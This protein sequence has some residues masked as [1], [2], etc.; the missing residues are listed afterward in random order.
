MRKRFLKT[1]TIDFIPPGGNTGLVNYGNKT[2]MWLV[3]LEQTDGCI[4]LHIRYG[5]DYRSPEHPRL[6]V[7]GFYAETITV[8]E[9]FG[10]LF[11]GNTFFP[12]VTFLP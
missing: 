3:Y 7:D 10:S 2:I 12:F 9:F 5:R 1:K 6:S 11:H 4:I 8:Y